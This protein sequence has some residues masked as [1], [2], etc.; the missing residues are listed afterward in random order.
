MTPHQREQRSLGS[1]FFMVGWYTYITLIW[2]LKFNMLCL[3]QRVVSGV[4]VEKFIKPTMALVITSAI[5]IY[6]LFAVGCQPFNRLWQVL[7]DPGRK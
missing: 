6:I 3:Y 7:P 2:T 4:W 1:K 5:A